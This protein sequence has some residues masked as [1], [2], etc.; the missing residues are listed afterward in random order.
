MSDFTVPDE[1]LGSILGQEEID[2]VAEVIRSGKGMS[3][4]G[5]NI[6]AL[7]REFADYCGAKRAVAVSSCTSALRIATQLLRL[8][9]GDEII[10]TPQTFRATLLAAFARGV[11][12]R[13]GDIDPRTLNIDP[14]TIEPLITPKTKA[15][16]LVH[17]GGNPADMDPILQIARKHGLAVVDDAAHAPGG[18]Y[19]GR[20]VGAVGD[21][22]CFSFHSMKNMTT[23]GE[24]GM[25]TT[26]ND[27]FAAEAKSLRSMGVLGP[28]VDRDTPTVGPYG[29]ADPP[30]SD[31]S[32]LSFT[33]DYTAI[34]EW[35]THD[36]FSDVLAA[37]GRVQ[38][39]KL[40]RINRRRIEIARRY[41][42]AVAELDG[43]EPWQVISGA[44][45]VYHL[46]PVF[47]DRRRIRAGQA[48]IVRYFEDE[49]RVQIVQ[50]YF[51]VHLTDY[52]RRLGHKFRECPVCERVFFEEQINLPIFP[53]MTDEQ[54]SCVIDALR[55][56]SERF[57]E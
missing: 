7:E 9:E 31:H 45:C 48:E 22:T 35:G 26:D 10:A 28:M 54:I 38:L 51:P 39:R 25:L 13:F 21:I 46:Y 29:M 44:T 37:I 20:R 49:K 53:F 36:R 52:A 34:D 4:S 40:D 56:A 17:Y 8:R 19:K 12:I 50:R 3:F 2:A 15:V 18:Q 5:E 42:E 43:F 32:Q 6:P 16:F 55:G 33:H 1:Q 57:V 11:T 41:D 47:V 23:G 24:G 30:L 27:A 14:A